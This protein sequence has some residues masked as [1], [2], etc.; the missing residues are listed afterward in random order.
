MNINKIIETFNQNGLAIVLVVANLLLLWIPV[1]TFISDP[2]IVHY[3]LFYV[4]F[5]LGACSYETIQKL[6]AF[7]GSY[8]PRTYF[9]ISKFI[10]SFTSLT[11]F[12]LYFFKNLVTASLVYS[13]LIIIV[14]I[15][16]FY[17][18]IMYPKILRRDTDNSLKN[19][20]NWKKQNESR[21]LKE[22]QRWLNLSLEEKCNEICIRIKNEIYSNYLNNANSLL[23]EWEGEIKDFKGSNYFKSLINL[24]NTK[25]QENRKENSKEYNWQCS[26]CGM[27]VRQ[28]HE[29][30]G[31]CNSSNVH[32][33][34]RL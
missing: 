10:L 11:F 23:T 1:C 25:V 18:I 19:K 9:D 4:V 33:W 20:A 3:I 14:I 6:F 28:H 16:Y 2:R 13:I 15:A 7:P 32:R 29:P 17:E 26:K 24:Y 22:K 5:I 34:N 8:G 12:L 27:L 31:K 30:S 21:K